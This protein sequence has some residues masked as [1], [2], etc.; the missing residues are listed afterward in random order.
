MFMLHDVH[1]L[2][3]DMKMKSKNAPKNKW[4]NLIYKNLKEKESNMFTLI[5]R[6]DSFIMDEMDGKCSNCAKPFRR[7]ETINAGYR[8][9]DSCTGTHFD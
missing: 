6:F 1:D 8:Y 4:G 3:Y 9:C 5:D 2:L 7:G